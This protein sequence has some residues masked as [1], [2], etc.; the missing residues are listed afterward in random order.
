MG[1]KQGC[2]CCRLVSA[3]TTLA[4][5]GGGGYAAWFFLGQPTADEIVDYAKGI[6]EDIKNIDF[7]DLT[8]ALENFT[9]FTPDLWNEDPFVGDNSTNVWRGHTSGEGGL[10]LELW[11]AL[12]ESWQTEYTEAVGDWNNWCGVKSVSLTTKD[13]E[14]DNACVQADGVMKVCNGNYGETGWLG[15]NEVLKSVP[16][17]IIQSSVAKMN[18]HY[19]L[20]AD[21]DERL[22]TMCHELGHGYGLPHTD[23]N[24]SNKD[25]GNC[26]DYTNTPSNNLRPG[27]ANCQR[28]LEMYGSVTGRRR[29]TLGREEALRALRYRSDAEVYEDETDDYEVPEGEDEDETDDADY[30]YSD[31]RSQYPNMTAEYEQAVHELYYEIAEGTIPKRGCDDRNNNSTEGVGVDVEDQRG[32]ERRWRRLTEHKRGGNFARRLNDGFE[33]EVHVLYPFHN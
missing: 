29:R 10:Y 28:L 33:L 32:R 11:N 5:L 19:L 17:G 4:I 23:E 14:V 3:F 31:A 8:G 15:I 7:G 30:Y 13:V 18:E 27:T 26:L 2:S 20:N 25:L 24:F 12:D 21:Y 22:Y 1:Q 6:G 9:G 16:R